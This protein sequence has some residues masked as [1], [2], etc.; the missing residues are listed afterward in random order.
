MLD[1]VIKNGLIIDGSG[2]APRPGAV[3]IS[4]DRIV[5]LGPEPPAARR[6]IDA[7][8]QIIAP[9]FIDT[10]AHSEFTLLADGSAAGKLSQ[11]VTTE[12]N[13]NCGL[14]AAPLYGEALERRI[15]DLEE[16]GV[17]ER[18]AT[19][20]EYFPLL[21]Q[22]G[23]GFNVATLC[24]HG[25]LRASVMG[26]RDGPP[27]ERD[28]AEMKR[29][30]TG[31]VLDGAKGLST[32]LIYPPGVYAAT[33]ELIELARTIAGQGI[34]AS[35]MRSEG[36]GLIESLDEV[37]RIGR[38][39]SLPVHVSHVKTSG[40][41]NWGKVDAA[42]GRMEGARTEGLRLTCD[43]YPYI[44]ASTDLDTVLPAWVYEGGVE[45]ELRRLSDPATAARIKE[46]LGGRGD[47][48]WHTV[49][50]SSVA[51]PEN[52]RMEGKSIV[53]IA[54]ERGQTVI[55][56]LIALLIE[57]RVRT[58]AIFF[59]MNEDNLRRFLSLPY[60]MIGSDS[61]VR[62]LSGPTRIG[63]PHPRAFGTFPRFL[64]R[65]VRDEGLMALPEAIRRVTSLPAA[66]F[67]LGQR[68]LLREGYFADLVVFDFE[69]LKDTATFQE[70]YQLAEGIRHVFVNGEA[71]VS[72]GRCTGARS[73]RVLT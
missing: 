50:V 5:S 55:D 10:H 49:Y 12:I 64:G 6:T 25:N 33:E 58:G 15:A 9:G 47:A 56:A 45:A 27:G 73:G 59:S 29:L 61:S 28:L 35:H 70:P 52:R 22:R 69:A 21:R 36:D 42:I 63:T 30:L 11:G 19:F 65:Y 41:R 34:Y 31:A 40:Q 43:R 2:S 3:G 16:V 71:A 8:Q 18:W 39:A 32:G 26:Y 4:G 62:G 7:G 38:E 48:Y 14:S 20:R 46:E 1:I 13:G 72:E 60:T 68:G 53:T 54:A 44:A 51:L 37:I 57:E 17:T 23:I 24:G 67:G 66:T